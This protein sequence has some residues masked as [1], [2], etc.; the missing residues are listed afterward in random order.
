MG[1]ALRDAGCERRSLVEHDR[2]ERARHEDEQPRVDRPE[3]GGERR[4]ARLDAECRPD[5]ARVLAEQRKQGDTVVERDRE[6][7]EGDVDGDERRAAPDGEEDGDTG[8]VRAVT[9]VEERGHRSGERRQRVHRP[10]ERQPRGRAPLDELSGDCADERDQH[11][12]LPAEEDEAREDEDECER[13]GAQA[14]HLE[15]DGLQLGEEREPE[16]QQDR[17]CLTSAWRIE[18]DAHRSPG[19]HRRRERD[20]ARDQ[21]AKPGRVGLPCRL[22]HVAVRSIESPVAGVS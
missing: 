10:V 7:D 17:G 2:E 6:R 20:C 21:P 16:E 22:G 9:A 15:R 12:R 5:Q 8:V 14:L 4:Q 13:D 18:S 3:R 11:G 1:V 19:H